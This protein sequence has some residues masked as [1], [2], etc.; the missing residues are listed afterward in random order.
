MR[1]TL[2]SFFGLVILLSLFLTSCVPAPVAPSSS[3]GQAKKLKVAFV[4]S[5][6][7]S[8]GAFGTIA[9]QSIQAVKKE[10]FIEKA[11]YIEGIN[12][13]TDA[14]KSI[15]DYVAEGY[16]VVWAHSGAHG[17]AVMEIAPQFPN[18]EFVALASPPKD[19]KFDNV[20]FSL[21]EYEGGYYIAG[22]LAAKMSKSNVIGFVGGRENPL[23]TAC[24]KAYEQGAKSINPNVKV[25]AVFTGDFNDPVKAKEATVSQIQSGADVIAHLQSLGMTGVFAAAE[26]SLKAGKKVWV[27]GKDNDQFPQAP[28]VVLTSLIIDYSVQMKAILGEIAAGKKSGSMPQSVTN[29]AVYLADF[30]GRVPADVVTQINALTDKVKKGEVKYTTQYDLQ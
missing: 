25:L 24:S 7:I 9:Y 4:L 6:S 10:P 26:E 1:R 23:Y 18:T 16:D 12:A 28:D 21:S 8:D 30:Y 5:G 14:A 3:S 27:I 19:K 17:P 15:R 13:A 22:A 11:T 29:G 20:W 2:G